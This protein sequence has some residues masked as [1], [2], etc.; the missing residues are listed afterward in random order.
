MGAFGKRPNKWRDRFFGNAFVRVLIFRVIVAVPTARR[1]FLRGGSALYGG[2]AISGKRAPELRIVG[3]ID[4][5]ANHLLRID[6]ARGFWLRGD[7]R[8]VK[9]PYAEAAS[10]N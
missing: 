6:G 5:A 2:E 7:Y 10:A 9:S 3:D 4:S 1:R 8:L